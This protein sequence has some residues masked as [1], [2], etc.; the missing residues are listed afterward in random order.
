M[1]LEQIYRTRRWLAYL[2]AKERVAQL[3]HAGPGLRYTWTTWKARD[4][5]LPPPGDWLVWLL[6]NRGFGKTRTGA[7]TIR[8]WVEINAAR[9][10]A[11]VAP[12]AA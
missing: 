12:T 11:L 3:R 2:P 1:T 6:C 7:E 9:S 5:Q 8:W 10:Y 4:S